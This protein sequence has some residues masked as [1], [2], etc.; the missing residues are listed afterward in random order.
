M[1]REYL[2][3]CEQC[4]QQVIRAET[5]NGRVVVIDPSAPVYVV[6][7]HGEKILAERMYQG[8]PLHQCVTEDQQEAE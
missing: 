1:R 3:I 2:R 6:T 7:Q 5:H 4:K 8:G